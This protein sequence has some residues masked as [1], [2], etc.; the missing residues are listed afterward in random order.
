MIPQS[1]TV[2]YAA[3]PLQLK[4]GDHRALGLVLSHFKNKASFHRNLQFA[5]MDLEDFTSIP[6]VFIAE[7]LK[8][9]P[10]KKY[11]KILENIYIYLEKNYLQLKLNFTLM[12]LTVKLNI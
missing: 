8:F 12:K 11:L 6:N 7:N 2:S 1:I 5:D 3:T 4:M 9:I 10:T